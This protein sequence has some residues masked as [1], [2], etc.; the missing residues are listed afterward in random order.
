[1]IGYGFLGLVAALAV[2]FIYAYNALIKKRNF[3]A[4]GWSGI[5]VQLRRRTDLVPNLVDTVKGYAAHERSLFEEVAAR[6][7]SSIAANNV[8]GQAAA[9]RDLQG[10]L[11]RLFAVAEAYPEL[12]ANKLFLD[13][14]KQL[15]EIE[16]QLQ[17]AR[18]YYNGTVRDLNTSIQSFPNNIVASLLR[19]KAESFFEIENRAEAVAPSVGFL[20]QKK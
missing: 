11:A 2:Y 16:D 14:Q 7:A 10:S 15:A 20:E 4:E 18:R 12:M 3:V 9:E 6:R 17:M 5:D 1:M 19:I 8:G 13:L